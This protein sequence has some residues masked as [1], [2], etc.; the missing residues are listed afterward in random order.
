Q[1][2]L[3]QRPPSSHIRWVLFI[4]LVVAAPCPWYMFAG[5]G[6][7]PLPVIA[8]FVFDEFPLVVL[9]NLL[10]VTAY[11]ALFLWVSRLVGKHIN[12]VPVVLRTPAV[13]VVMPYLHAWSR[14]RQRKGHTAPPR[15]AK[16]T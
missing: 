11:G 2:R 6:L 14:R 5:G 12:A 10:Q 4:A 8:G 1:E 16:E 3:P 9:V 13:A 7:L 15:S